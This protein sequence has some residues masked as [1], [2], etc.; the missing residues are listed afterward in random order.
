MPLKMAKDGWKYP[1]LDYTHRDF[2]QSLNCLQL[3]LQ[4]LIQQQEKLNK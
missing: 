4:H 3:Q 2:R 1:Y